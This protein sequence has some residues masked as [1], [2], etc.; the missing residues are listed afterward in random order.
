MQVELSQT[1]KLTLYHQDEKFAI[2]RYNGVCSGFS[3]SPRMRPSH[4]EGERNLPPLGGLRGQAAVTLGRGNAYMLH[5]KQRGMV[6]TQSATQSIG[7]R[8]RLVE[9]IL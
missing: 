7:T 9:D 4:W 1:V 3:P 8:K 5:W 6:C 2:I